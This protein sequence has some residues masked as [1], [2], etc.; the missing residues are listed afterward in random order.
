M[1]E[2]TKILRNPYFLIFLFSFLPF[3]L[4]FLN[5]GLI[6]THDSLVH[7]PRI[8][9]Y[10]KSLRDFHF[11]VRWAGDLNYGYGMPLF[12]FIYPLPYFISSS[13]LFLGLGLVNSFKIVLFLSFLFS[14]FFMF[15]FAKEFFGDERKAIF[16]TFFYQ[17]AP[18]RLVEILLRGD[19]GEI[20]TYTFLPLALFAVLRIFKTHN[21]KSFILASFST[22][23]L[24]LSHNSVSLLFSALLILFIIFFAKNK[25]DFFLG[26]SA[27]LIG[28]LIASFYWVPAILEHKYTHGDLYMKTLYQ[29]YFPNISS[30]F[31]PNPLNLDF[32]KTKGIATDIGFFHVIAIVLAMVFMFKKRTQARDKKIIIFSFVLIVISIF[33]MQPVSKVFWQNLALLRQ[34]QFPWRFLPIIVF[35]SSLLSVFYLNLSFFKK[36][37]IF[38]LTVFLVVIYTLVYWNPIL[39]FD[40]IDKKR[41]DYYWNFPLTTTYYGE[42]DVIWGAG[43]AK[44]FPKKRIDIVS[45]QGKISKF[46]KKSTT[47]EFNVSSKADI[48]LVSHTQYFPGW[49]VYVDKKK[50]PI[51]FQDINYR[52][53]IKFP[54][55]KGDHHVRLS[56]LESKVRFIADI[57]SLL[58]ILFMISYI[59]VGIRHFINKK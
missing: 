13:L 56:F 36:K 44:S 12:N 41:A 20:Y 43:P 55:S 38:Y 23:L 2:Y 15:L 59:A 39:G 21:K 14:G 32:L 45:G 24:I 52:G 16:V 51:E 35:A 18:F 40:K 10:F 58:T 28:V 46:S 47:Q 49:R 11:P 37:F 3:L 8:A 53:E 33:F 34:F 1:R 54:V 4:V 7:L 25:K 57:V 30:L 5:S 48:V 29:S 42:T 27:L 26:I 50:V 9:A 17:F 22:A 19:I 6:H 31:I